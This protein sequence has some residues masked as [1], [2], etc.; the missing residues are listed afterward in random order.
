MS[1]TLLFKALLTV[2]IAAVIAFLLVLTIPERHLAFLEGLP[3]KRFLTCL[4][5]I[6]TAVAAV[7][8]YHV[9]VLPTPPRTTVATLFVIVPLFGTGVIASASRPELLKFTP[10]PVGGLPAVEMKWGGFDIWGV[11]LGGILLY[12][13]WALL[14]KYDDQYYRHRAESTP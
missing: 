4:L 13:I 9:V 14:R 1:P 5:A 11:V 10:D 3:A 2:V 7:V 6:N 8:V 12:F